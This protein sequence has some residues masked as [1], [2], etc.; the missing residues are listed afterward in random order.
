MLSFYWAH[1]QVEILKQG[2]LHFLIFFQQSKIVIF[3]MFFH[4]YY[5]IRLM[6]CNEAFPTSYVHG[7]DFKRSCITMTYYTPH[8]FVLRWVDRLIII[9]LKICSCD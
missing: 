4:D 8:N 5:D 6:V 7:Q 2:L 3:N 1:D 9:H